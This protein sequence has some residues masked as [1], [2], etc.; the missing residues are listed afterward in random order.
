MTRSLRPWLA[1]I[2]LSASGTALATFHTY[3]I[4]Q[5]FS[6]AGG[7]VQ[8]VVLHEAAGMD[9]QNHWGGQML[10]SRRGTVTKTFVF[11]DDLPGPPC[12]PYYGC[13]GAPTA[14]TRVL[15]AT[16]GFAALGLIRP[17]YVVPNGFLFTEG[18]TLDFAGVDVVT[19]AA[20]PVDGVTAIDRRGNRIPN[21][22]TN[23]GGGARSIAGAAGA[24]PNHQGLYWASP[25]G[26]ESGWG[27]NVAHQGDIVFA[28]LFTYDAAG[29][30]LWLVMSAGLKQADGVTYAGTLYRTT[31]P[32]FNASP[33]TP[34]TAAN[35]TAVGTMSIAFPATGAATLNY[36]VNGAAVAKTIVKQVYGQRAADCVPTTASR[37]AL[38]NY[39]DLWWNPAESGWGV[40]I[41]QQDQILFA[42]L[43]TYDAGGRNLWLVMSNGQRQADGSYLGELYRTTGPAFNAVPFTPIGAANV[44]AVGTMRFRFTDGGNGTLTYTYQGAT[45][46]KAI[47]RQEFA[48]PLPSCS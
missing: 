48:S 41:T 42:T 33:F 16:E 37:A 10:T 39:Q 26:S 21:V 2:L 19:Y 23:F 18:G 11:P 40:N 12:D 32:A 28:T 15:V 29:A 44:T 45:V 20:L 13:E 31:G 3:Q 27:L 7:A 35:L 30:P 34:I 22:A 25:A 14:D 47:T 36:T 43:F 5:L 46:T 38:A 17:D 8:F 24:T 9:G 4:E 1:A 6:D